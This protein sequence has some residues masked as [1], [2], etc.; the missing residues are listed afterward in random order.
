MFSIIVVAYSIFPLTFVM[1]R[2]LSLVT[3]SLLIFGF[4]IQSMHDVITLFEHLVILS[5][6]EKMLFN[7]LLEHYNAKHTPT[8]F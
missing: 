8:D 5:L 1:V 7:M 6:L 4:F 3:S 2:F